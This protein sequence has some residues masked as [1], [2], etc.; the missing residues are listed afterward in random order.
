MSFEF[1]YLVPKIENQLCIAFQHIVN[2]KCFQVTSVD[3]K[4][5]NNKLYSVKVNDKIV[6][7]WGIS[8]S[9]I[10]PSQLKKIINLSC[11]SVLIKFSRDLEGT[12]TI[13]TD[14]KNLNQQINDTESIWNKLQ[15][16]N[17]DQSLVVESKNIM[18]KLISSKNH[19]LFWKCLGGHGLGFKSGESSSFYLNFFGDH[20][21]EFSFGKSRSE[22]P[23]RFKIRQESQGHPSIHNWVYD[24]DDGGIL[25]CQANWRG[26]L[27][28]ER[29]VL[30]SNIEIIAGDMSL[31]SSD[32]KEHSFKLYIEFN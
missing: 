22:G 15:N 18:S 16:I 25:Y 23:F 10:S 17:I 6:E 21:F 2:L 19:K 12:D 20:T 5:N 7:V 9:K 3:E 8:V 13:S 29:T 24:I 28:L 11:D 30:K 26:V 32:G 1:E 14:K 27:F 31:E 4:V